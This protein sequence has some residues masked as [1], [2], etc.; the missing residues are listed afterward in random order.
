M[1]PTK[2]SF[3]GQVRSTA[4]NLWRGS[5]WLAN[6]DDSNFC[7]GH[8]I[9]RLAMRQGT[10]SDPQIETRAVYAYVADET[11]PDAIVRAVFWDSKTVVRRGHRDPNDP[12]ANTPFTIPAKF[13]QIPITHVRRWVQ[14]FDGLQTSLQV[15]SVEEDLPICSL[16]IET[17]YVDN[18]FEKVWQVLPGEQD[19]IT[20]IWLEVWH[21]MGHMLQTCQA[22]TSVKESFPCVE[23]KPEVYDLQAYEPVLTL[24]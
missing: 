14:R 4:Y 3:Y 24:P 6:R 15:V 8:R 21:E 20:R 2:I 12:P 17:S 18:V 10:S 22:L 11:Q 9:L 5:D 16:R 13:V 23:G 7:G 19:E 1:A